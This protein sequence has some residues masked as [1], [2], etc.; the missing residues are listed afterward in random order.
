MGAR[1]KRVRTDVSIDTPAKTIRRRKTGK[2]ERLLQMPLEILLEVS[3]FTF[4]S[5]ASGLDW[6]VVDLSISGAS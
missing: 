2:L 5:E 1:A 6:F 4:P 3:P